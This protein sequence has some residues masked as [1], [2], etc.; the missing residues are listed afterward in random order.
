[1]SSWIIQVGD[2]KDH[3]RIIAALNTMRLQHKIIND[4]FIRVHNAGDS[5]SMR[6]QQFTTNPNLIAPVHIYRLSEVF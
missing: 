1:M 4:R 3:E 6:L 2:N 5:L